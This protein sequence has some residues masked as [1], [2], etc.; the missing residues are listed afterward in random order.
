MHKLI[1]IEGIDCSGKSSVA[2]EVAKR[3]G[4]KFEHEP[5]FSSEYADSVNFGQ[6]NAYQR[7]FHFMIDR[8]KHQECLNNNNVIL[9][10]Y[11]LSG[12]AY[13]SVFGPEALDM[14]HGIYALPEFKVPDLTIFLD[15]SPENALKLN[16]KKQGTDEYNSNLTISTLTKLRNAFLEQMLVIRNIWQENIVIVPAIYGDFEGT[17]CSVISTI[18]Q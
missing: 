2:K 14:I 18:N 12:A 15:M 5:T 8:Y 7:E 1:V 4:Y 16:E 11:R 13:A 9:D 3:M 6:M 17:I 10:R